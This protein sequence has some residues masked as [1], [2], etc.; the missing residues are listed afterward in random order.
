[1]WVILAGK[2]LGQL[3]AKPRDRRRQLSRSPGRFAEPERNRRRLAVSVG[4]PNSSVL[5]PHNLPRSVAELKYIALHAL[6]RPVFVYSSDDRV[7]RFE[8]DGVIGCVGDRTARG[9]RRKPRAFSPAP[10]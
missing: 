8:H 6:D 7:R 5:D 9:D 4:D 3:S 2:S 1:F 10:S